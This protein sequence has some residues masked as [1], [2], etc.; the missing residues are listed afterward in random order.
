MDKTIKVRYLGP[1]GTVVVTPE[2]ARK[3]LDST[4]GGKLS[5]MAVNARTGETVNQITDDI[6][7]IIVIEHMSGDQ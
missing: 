2:E 1:K 3:I 4:Y 6:D 7:E 5:G